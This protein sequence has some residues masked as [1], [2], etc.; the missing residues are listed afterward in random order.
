MKQHAREA[1]VDAQPRKRPREI[2]KPR[3]SQERDKEG[4]GAHGHQDAADPLDAT[5]HAASAGCPVHTDQQIEQR[6]KQQ[7]DVSRS[8][9]KPRRVRHAPQVIEATI[10]VLT[11]RQESND[12]E[13]PEQQVHTSKNHQKS[14]SAQRSGVSGVVLS[15]SEDPRPLQR[16][17]G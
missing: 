2:M 16:R 12:A 17:L 9:Q 4:D 13:N 7:V 11:S 14:F 6:R 8:K 10:H 5:S 15:E 3:L 1:G